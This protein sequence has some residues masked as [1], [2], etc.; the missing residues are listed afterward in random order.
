MVGK[1]QY[2]FGTGFEKMLVK[3]IKISYIVRTVTRSSV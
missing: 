2:V 1:E 3:K